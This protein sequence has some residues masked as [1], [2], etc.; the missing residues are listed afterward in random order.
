[1][2]FKINRI[3]I[4]NF[5]SIQSKITLDVKP[6]LF[7]IEGI[8]YTETNSTNGVGKTT[9]IAALFWCLTGTSLTNEAL[10]DEVVNLKVGKNCKVSVYIEFNSNEI[11]ITHGLN[12]FSDKLYINIP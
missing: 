11:K 3:E 6:G 2:L 5:R 7:C 4:E 1:M 10:A 8:N 9:L 12:C